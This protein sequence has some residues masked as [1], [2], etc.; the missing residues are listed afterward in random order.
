MHLLGFP[1]QPQDSVPCHLLLCLSPETVAHWAWAAKDQDVVEYPRAFVQED[2]LLSG[3]WCLGIGLW[4]L[5]SQQRGKE[6]GEA[7]GT[8]SP[9]VQVPSWVQQAE[10]AA[11]LCSWLCPGTHPPQLAF[12]L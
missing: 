5:K 9:E 10:E 2:K 7:F 1:G 6:E 8:G 4:S 11:E 3:V 12:S